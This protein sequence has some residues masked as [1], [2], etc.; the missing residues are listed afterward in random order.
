VK[1]REIMLA[2]ALGALMA[3]GAAAQDAAGKKPRQ[4]AKEMALTPQQRERVEEI[5]GDSC[6]FCHGEKGEAS[7]PI[8]P[9]LA[10]QNRDYMIRQL[11]LFRSGQR[12]SEI[13]N[14]QAAD[15]T[16]EDIELL[17]TWFSAQ[18]PLAHKLS[19]YEQERL[20]AKVGE[21]VFRYGDP[22]ADIPPCMT[23]HGKGG[24]GSRELPRLAGQHR[25]YIV[26]QLKAFAS[27]QRQTDNA[28][29]RSIARNLSPL[30]MEGVALYL[31]TLV[32]EKMA[33][34]ARR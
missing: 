10:G 26:K 9:R 32:P 18:P 27:G 22:H 4:E 24:E 21:Y 29:M 25:R 3:S 11:K 16:D 33:A 5:I 31:S 23:C 6:V 2:V 12:K 1:M 19:D 34:G 15:L 28:I 20:L 17:A 8:Y 14:A 30:A 7:N 13:M